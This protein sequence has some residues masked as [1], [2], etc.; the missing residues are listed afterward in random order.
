MFHIS[1]SFGASGGLC[2]VIAAF[3]GYLHLY[4]LLYTAMLLA[5]FLTPPCPVNPHPTLALAYAVSDTQSN[6]NGLNEPK[7]NKNIICTTVKYEERPFTVST[8]HYTISAAVKK[9]KDKSKPKYYH[10]LRINTF[11]HTVHIKTQVTVQMLQFI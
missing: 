2:I 3:P 7:V 9:D 10:Y 8:R 11:L 5:R 4:F 6:Q 1:P